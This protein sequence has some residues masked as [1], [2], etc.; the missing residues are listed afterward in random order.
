VLVEIGQIVIQTHIPII[1]RQ[2]AVFGIQLE[3]IRDP[4][5]QRGCVGLE[6]I[7]IQGAAE[8]GIVHAIK[9]IRQRR[10]SG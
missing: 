1:H 5:Q 8:E 3:L 4:G 6:N 10:L 9:D 7:A 2:G